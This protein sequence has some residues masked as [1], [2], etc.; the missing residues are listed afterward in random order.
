MLVSCF[1]DHKIRNSATQ[2]A[3][4][5]KEKSQ[6]TSSK[7]KMLHIICFENKKKTTKCGHLER[8]TRFEQVKPLKLPLKNHYK[9]GN[10]E[11]LS[12]SQHIKRNI[13]INNT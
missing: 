8:K 7:S 2:P 3:T 11:I 6:K 10:Y 5:L 13:K 4:H 1:N 9:I 12:T